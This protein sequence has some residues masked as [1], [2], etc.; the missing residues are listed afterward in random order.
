MSPQAMTA[1]ES[2]L[3]R[4]RGAGRRS[5]SALPPT[6][7][8]LATVDLGSNSFRLEV[9]RLEAGRYVRTDYLKEAVRQGG[10]LDAERRLTPAAMEAGLQCLARFA[11]RLRDFEAHEVRA[12]ATQTLREA[13]NRDAFIEQANAVLG[14]PIEIIS[15]REE[16]R[17]IYAGVCSKL[18]PMTDQRRLVID[19][20]GRSTELITGSG[21]EAHAME[22]YRLG[23]I[24][25]SA[26]YFAQGR[27][28]A[29]NFEIARIA[30]LA[31]LDEALESF[32]PGQWETVYGSAGTV[33]AIGRALEC[34]GWPPGQ[35]TVQGLQWL[36]E[37]MIEVGSSQHLHLPG[38]RE[39]RR[40]IIGGGTSILSALFQLFQIDH[41]WVAEGGLRHGLV[42]DMLG[43][44]PH[45]DMRED[46][47]Q[48][49]C[50][51]FGVDAGQSERVALVA[52]H[53]FDLAHLPV[54][55]PPE[56][57][58]VRAK[59]VWAAKLHEIGTRV[60]HSDFH[61]HG[62]YVLQNADTPGFTLPEMQR[63][64]L[65]VLG[66]RGKLRK[67][68]DAL[69]D[70]TLML[71]VLCLR[72]A[73]LLCHARRPP[74]LSSLQL[75]MDAGPTRH[76]RLAFSSDWALAHPQ[77][78]HLLRAESEAWEKTGWQFSLLER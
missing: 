17:L 65:L 14:F 76:M 49:L 58:T 53:L 47:V 67:L 34:A 69:D 18:P 11:E 57:A 3:S 19:I 28:S 26:R 45:K 46:A 60:S 2:P 5:R 77:S 74:E 42:Q 75:Q 13:R 16:A 56:R 61:K 8:H 7:R 21:R 55:A 68:G 38:I 66:Q 62:A 52:A 12:V 78:L 70:A 31:V 41:L 44:R 48:H 10:G 64:S 9:G 6:P 35:I 73:V 22:S 23:S 39:D 63:L 51:S 54:I 4:G 71:Q 15:G 43:Q 33:G 24:A 32:G 20:G 37:E 27:F 59:L 29:G 1:I 25:W 72:L 36:I 30:A 50:S 40:E